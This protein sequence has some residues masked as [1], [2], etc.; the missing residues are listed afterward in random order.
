MTKTLATLALASVVVAAGCT[1]PADVENVPVGSEVEVIRQDGGVVRGTLAERDER[2][3]KDDVGPATHSAT[4][5]RVREVDEA[6]DAAPGRQVPRATP[7]GTKLVAR[8]SCRRFRPSRGSVGAISPMRIIDD[9]D[10][11]RERRPGRG[12]GGPAGWKGEGPGE[13][14]TPVHVGLGRRARR[15]VLDD[16]SHRHAGAGHER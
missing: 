13:T 9:A 2:A 14:G 12:G 8:P 3:V 4:D 6:A 16:G 15:A 10:V 1:R 5:R 11:C 7:E